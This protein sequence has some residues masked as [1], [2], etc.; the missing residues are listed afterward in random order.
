MT[1]C[2]RDFSCWSIQTRP[3]VGK[4]STADLIRMRSCRLEEVITR[5]D[6]IDAMRVDADEGEI[7]ILRFE[8]TAQALFNEWREVLERRLRDGSE[9]P[10]MEAHLA[11]YRSMVPSLALVLHLTT[12]VEGPIDYEALERAIA[13]AEYLEPHARRV[14]AP[15]ISPDLT[16]AHAI[17]ARIKAGD[18]EK[19]FTARDV[20]RRGWSGLSTRGCR[21]GRPKSIRGL[22]LGLLAKDGNWAADLG[23][24]TSSTT[25]C[26]VGHQN[27]RYAAR[28]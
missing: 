1:V 25:R 23:M 15:G 8:P 4:T 16:A 22:L 13:W 11:K 14:Y 5:L 9:H 18:V 24:T 26:S 17:A 10:L 7:P 27:E 3:R 21:G 28:S 12:A 2:Y 20:Y 19:S 6:R